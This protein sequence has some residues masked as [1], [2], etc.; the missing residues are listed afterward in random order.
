MQKKMYMWK[1]V[2]IRRIALELIWDHMWYNSLSS[3]NIREYLMEVFSAMPA[4]K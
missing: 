3:L 2:Y 1:N 4:T